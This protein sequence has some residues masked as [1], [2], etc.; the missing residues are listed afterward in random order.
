[1]SKTQI[2]PYTIQHWLF[3]EA[4]GRFD[5]DLGES[6]IQHHHIEDLHICT[7][8]DLNYCQDRGHLQLRQSVAEMYGVTCEQVAITNGSQEGL[9]LF[10]Q[11][12]LQKG[13]HVITFTPGW[14]QSW[15]V[16]CFLGAEVTK[17]PLKVEDGYRIDWQQVRDCVRSNSRLLILT[18]PN[19]P[20]GTALSHEDRQAVD[21]LIQQKGMFVLN[22]EEYLTDYSSSFCHISGRTA[23]VSSL[24]KIYGF[25]GLRLGWLIS[26]KDTVDAVVNMKRYTSVCNSSL[27]EYLAVQV[28]QRRQEFVDRY[29]RIQQDGLVYLQDWMASVDCMEMVPPQGTP[30]AYIQLQS[31]MSSMEFCR[32]LLE[33]ERVLI[34]PAEVFED[35]MALR[36]SF[37]RHTD[38]LARGLEKVGKF[39]IG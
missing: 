9:Y 12:L 19:N 23:V 34:M 25:P 7:N 11:S 28:L 16:P 20:T 24:S 15:E 3:D 36:I 10:Y 18:Y 32:G 8:Y 26:D 35:Q 17:I 37:G 31:P 6:G 13:D 29:F 38:L 1:M 21:E 33:Q 14:Q 30:F 27:C 39:I 22:D 2:A 5:I 4:D